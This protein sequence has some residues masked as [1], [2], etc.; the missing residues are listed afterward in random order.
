MRR[1]WGRLCEEK[2][3]STLGQPGHLSCRLEDGFVEN[4]PCW[5][6]SPP[7]YAAPPIQLHYAPCG[8]SDCMSSR[9]LLEAGQPGTTAGC[10]AFSLG[11]KI[12]TLYLSL[13]P[14][15]EWGRRL[16]ISVVDGEM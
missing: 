12:G 3:C 4:L 11:L 2:V 13:T 14:A 16:P 15:E 10:M 7:T 5:V 9:S 1:G 6:V 8:L